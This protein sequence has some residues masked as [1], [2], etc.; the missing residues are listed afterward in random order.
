[1]RLVCPSCSAE[2]EVA[3]EAVGTKGRMVRCAACASEWFQAPSAKSVVPQKAEPFIEPMQEP[4]ADPHPAEVATGDERAERSLSALS[5]FDD[6]FDD[7]PE[8]VPATPQADNK[9]DRQSALSSLTSFTDDDDDDDVGRRQVYYDVDPEPMRSVDSVVEESLIPSSRRTEGI[10]ALTASLRS[11]ED[12]TDTRT[13]GAF[14]AGFATITLIALVLIA[15]YVKAPEIA[16]LAP[17]VKGP[18]TIYADMV[19]QG[20]LALAQAT[21]GGA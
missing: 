20:R 1:M 3:A 9:A 4:Q 16:Q 7:E 19:D 15:V 6:D 5:G 8:V 18:L 21:N 13:G 2:Y 17:A 12:E 14:L 10:D 11:D